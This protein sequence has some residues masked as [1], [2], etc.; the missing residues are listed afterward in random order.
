[1]T[2]TI[3]FTKMH[4]AGND[5]IYINAIKYPIADPEKRAVE[6]SAYHTGIG[7]DGTCID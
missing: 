7:S 1:M 6:W 5:Y 3:Q 4:G 2:K